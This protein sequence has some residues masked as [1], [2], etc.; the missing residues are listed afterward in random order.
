M[1]LQT[2]ENDTQQQP[3]RVGFL[4]KCNPSATPRSVVPRAIKFGVIAAMI[5]WVAAFFKPSMREDWQIFF[6][7]AVGVAMIT[8]AVCE[9][10]V[11]NDQL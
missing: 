6:P 5:W 11:D 7:L 2:S 9:W 10:Q 4:S 3:R 8:C 1:P